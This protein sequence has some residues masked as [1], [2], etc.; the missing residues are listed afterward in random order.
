[1][2]G[3]SMHAALISLVLMSG[4][5]GQAASEMAA[6]SAQS[7]PE[8]IATPPGAMESESLVTF[9]ANPWAPPPVTV[10]V[11]PLHLPCGCG[12]IG[13]QSCGFRGTDMYHC[14]E[15]PTPPEEHTNPAWCSDYSP[16]CYFYPHCRMLF[17]PADYTRPYDYRER[18]NYPWNDPRCT[19]A[20]PQ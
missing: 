5:C 6:P 14:C 8:S 7:R 11:P 12:A 16:A 1:L 4:A 2:T 15:K 9:S 10:S 17:H 19:C 18:F 13:C 3:R 20:G